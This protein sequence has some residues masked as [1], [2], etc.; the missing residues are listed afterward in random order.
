MGKTLQSR[1]Q[2]VKLMEL[3]RSEIIRALNDVGIAEAKEETPLS[4]L[5]GMVRW[6]TGFG[7]CDLAT[8]EKST[9]RQRFFKA[10]DWEGM[11]AG[12]RSAYISI[13]VRFRAEARQWIIARSD[14]QD[15]TGLTAHHWSTELVN[16]PTLKDYN[17]TLKS[18]GFLSDFDGKGKT[19]RICAFAETKDGMRYPA[20]QLC[21]AYKAQDGDTTEWWLPDVSEWTLMQRYR[22]EIDTA[23]KRL[24]GTGLSVEYWTADEIGAYGAWRWSR[25]GFPS[26]YENKHTPNLCSRACAAVEN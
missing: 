20:A 7:S 6:A 2:S 12:Q 10:D 15:R 16:I 3:N 18:V 25:E 8:V 11:S 1:V 21:R 13:G 9:G 4:E 26:N 23:L 24:F 5:A 17:G 22:T 19:D 14:V